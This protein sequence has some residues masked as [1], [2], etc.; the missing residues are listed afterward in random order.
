[1]SSPTDHS[2]VPDRSKE[3]KGAIMAL[4]QNT[5]T[6]TCDRIKNDHDHR[7][8]VFYISLGSGA[9]S[10]LLY[11]IGAIS[12]RGERLG[13]RYV[14]DGTIQFNHIVVMTIWAMSGISAFVAVLTAFGYRRLCR[15]AEHVSRRKAMPNHPTSIIVSSRSGSM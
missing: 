11:C 6:T 14:S 4:I 3:Q 9:M 1:M 7:M 2:M 13:A 5:T 10:F 15:R 8:T 12:D